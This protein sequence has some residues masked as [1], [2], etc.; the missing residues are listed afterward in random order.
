METGSYVQQNGFGHEEWLFNFRWTQPLAAA[1]ERS[2]KYGFLQPLWK[3]RGAYEGKTFDVLVYTV[4]RGGER[5]AVATI[6]NLYVPLVP[7]IEEALGV[8]RG[9]GW[10]R[11]MKEDLS[12]LGVS[13]TALEV[14]ATDLINVRFDPADVVF[15]EP[16]VPFPRTHKLYRNKRYR[17]SDWDDD[18]LTDGNAVASEISSSLGGKLRSEQERQRA[19]IEGTAYS[20]QHVR[21]Q[22]ALY[23][24]LC[25]LHGQD[26]VQ[27]ELWNVVDLRVKKGG[28]TTFFEI[29][30]APTAK[31]CIRE[32]LGQL[33]EYGIYP[34]RLRAT[35]LVIVGDGAPAGDDRRY[36]SHLREKFGLPVL[37]QQW[38]WARGE[39]SQE[40]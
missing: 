24:H 1:V 18:F 25:D 5:I 19:A 21:L 4:G 10:L 39:L 33:L 30:I 8:M 14:P 26:A 37:Y 15:F 29:K 3:Y 23:K 27:Y 22:N 9:K 7:E 31:R 32:A 12:E 40:W 13:G 11:E 36:L 2:V 6:R 28:E 17:A 35:K 38:I 16:R 34:E 20:P